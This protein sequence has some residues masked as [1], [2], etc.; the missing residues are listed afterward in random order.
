MF[1]GSCGGAEARKS[2]FPLARLAERFINLLKDIY[3]LVA[4]E[5]WGALWRKTGTLRCYLH[6]AWVVIFGWVELSGACSINQPH[7]PS[8]CSQSPKD[9]PP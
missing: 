3:F 9:L 2:S 8:A 7:M 4:E 5:A 6:E 1:Q